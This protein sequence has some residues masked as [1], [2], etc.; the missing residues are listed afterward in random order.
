MTTKAKPHRKAA[1]PAAPPSDAPTPDVE[2]PPAALPPHD[3]PKA[4]GGKLGAFVQLLRRP[5]GATVAQLA[6]AAG[7]RAH[8]VRGAM[9]GAL[10]AR[11]LV[12]ASEKTEAGR[13]YR[14]PVPIPAGSDE[15]QS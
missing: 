14:L 11:G 3:E 12:V 13:I 9:A 10:K 7:W 1:A 6:A 15:A 2:A 5:E 4:P 8:S